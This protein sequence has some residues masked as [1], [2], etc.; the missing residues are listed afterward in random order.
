MLFFLLALESITQPHRVIGLGQEGGAAWADRPAAIMTAAIS[1]AARTIRAA[2][3]FLS[4]SMT[5]YPFRF[6]ER[7]CGRGR[8]LDAGLAAGA[9]VVVPA[10][11]VAVRIVVDHVELAVAGVAV[12]G[13][14]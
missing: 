12:D 1:A 10:V 5:R 6:C 8:L 4:R 11:V 9:H 13:D 7:F 2:S 3:H 14:D